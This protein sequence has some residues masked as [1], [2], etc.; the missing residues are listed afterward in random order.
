MLFRSLGIVL[1]T[2]GERTGG[3]AGL[4]LLND[5]VYAYR[6]ALTIWT[7]EHFSYYHEMASYN[8]ALVEAAIAAQRG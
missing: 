1:R 8:L 6:A 2:Q 7:R 3:D 4:A 5:A